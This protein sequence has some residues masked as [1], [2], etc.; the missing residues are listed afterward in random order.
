MEKIYSVIYDNGREFEYYLFKNK[1]NALKKYNRIYNNY[2]FK[3]N[4]PDE[5]EQKGYRINDLYGGM[6]LDLREETFDD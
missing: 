3:D 4:K 6:R 1:E 2:G 5:I